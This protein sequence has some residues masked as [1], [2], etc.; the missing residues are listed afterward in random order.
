MEHSGLNATRSSANFNTAADICELY[1]DEGSEELDY[2]KLQKATQLSEQWIK[3][4]DK[5]AAEQRSWLRSS[6]AGI[7]FAV[8]VPPEDQRDKQWSDMCYRLT[9]PN[10]KT[11]SVY[12]HKQS[13]VNSQLVDDPSQ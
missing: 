3:Q 1:F 4:A 10:A 7:T 13:L 5:Q 2:A 6:L 8:I 11:G 9:N 12:M